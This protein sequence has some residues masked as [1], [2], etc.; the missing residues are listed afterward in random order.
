MNNFNKILYKYLLK[1]SEIVFGKDESV[2]RISF[3]G[4]PFDHARKLVDEIIEGGGMVVNNRTIPVVLTDTSVPAH[5]APSNSMGGI[6]GNNHILNLRNNKDIKEVIVILGVGT[7]LDKSNSTSLIPLGIKENIQ[8]DEWINH[9]M[10]QFILGEI[11]LNLNISYNQVKGGVDDIISNYRSSQTHQNDHIDQWSLLEILAKQ[12]GVADNNLLAYLLGSIND[13]S[14]IQIDNKVQTKIFS[15]IADSFESNGFSKT[16]DEWLG[17]DLDFVIEN[18]LVDFKSHLVTVCSAPTDFKSCPNFYYG[19]YLKQNGEIV[20]PNWWKTLTVDVWNE[21]L[22][23]STTIAGACK[24]SVTNSVFRRDKPCPVTN[25]EVEFNIEHNDGFEVGQTIKISCKRRNYELLESIE[26]EEKCSSIN[27]SHQPNPHNSPASYKFEIEGHKDATQKVISLNAYAPAFM[28]FISQ[29]DKIKPLKRKKDKRSKNEI[30]ESSLVLA[31]SGTH[32]IEYLIDDKRVDLQEIRKYNSSND[33]KVET[34]TSTSIGEKYSTIFQSDNEGILEFILKDKESLIF[35]IIRVSFSVSDSEPIGVKS[36]YEKLVTQNLSSKG[37]NEKVEVYND[38]NDLHQIQKWLV[39]CKETSWNPIIICPDYKEK[40]QLPDYAAAPLLSPSEIIVDCRPSSDIMLPPQELISLRSK[41]ISLICI[42]KEEDNKT[43]FYQPLIEYAELYRPD[44]QKTIEPLIIEYLEIY[45]KWYNGSPEIASWFDTMAICKT[46]KGIVDT[47]P[48]ALLLSPYHP[49]R[50]GWQYLSQ[51]ELNKAL[52]LEK[53][54]PAAGVINPSNFPDSLLI[55]SYQIESQRKELVFISL[56]TSSTVWSLMWNSDKLSAIDNKKYNS[57]FSDEFGMIIEG[58]DNG[59]S[60]SQV[61]HTL[62]DIYRIKSGQNSI[63]IEVH[64]ESAESTMFNHGV[65]N[66]I[67][68]NLGD[69]I[70]ENNKKVV[71]DIWFDSGGKSLEIYDTRP[72]YFQPSSEELVEYSKET[73]YGLLWYKQNT[74]NGTQ[75]FDLSIISHLTSQSP[76]TNS[77]PSHS[78]LTNGGLSRNRI[79]YSSK[80]GNS[81]L[82]F[83]ESRTCFKPILNDDSLSDILGQTCYEI[84]SDVYRASK[85]C[86]SSTPKL[87]FVN[88]CMLNADYCAISS[89]VVDPSAFFDDENNNYLWDYELPSYSNKHNTYSGFYLL[90]KKTDSVITSIKNSLKAIPSIGKISDEIIQGTLKEIAGRGIPTLK[91]LA[92]GG[93][94]ANGEIGMLLGMKF[95]QSFD[96]HSSS[97]QFAPRETDNN[98]NLIIPIDPFA[99]QL[100]GLYSRLGID[101]LRPDLVVLSVSSKNDDVQIKL[102][103]IEIKYR[104]NKMSRKD[105]M[106]AHLQCDNFIKLCKELDLLSRDFDLWNVARMQ[107]L[108]DM[109]SFAFGTYGRQL[110]ELNE[111]REWSSLQEQVLKKI[112]TPNNIIYSEIGRLIIVSDYQLTDF[113]CVKDSLIKDTL[114]VSFEDAKNVLKSENL[115]KF[116]KFQDIVGDWGLQ[117]A[118]I[119]ESIKGSKYEITTD[120]REVADPDVRNERIEDDEDLSINKTPEE[121]NNGEMVT[122]KLEIAESVNGDGIKFQVGYQKGALQNISHEF[123]P[124]NT[125][126]NQLNIGIVGDLGTGKTQLIKA[127]IYNISKDSSQNRGQSPKFLIIDTKRDYDGSGDKESDKKFV[128]DINAKVIK[129][130]KLPINLFDIRNSKDDNPAFTKAEFFIDILTKIYGGIQAVQSNALLEAVMNSFYNAGYEPFAEDYSNFKSPTLKDVFEE[131]KVNCKKVDTS[132]A[133]MNRLIQARL[134][135][136]DS[137]KTVGFNDFFNQTTVLS[138]G[139]MASNDKNLKMVMIIFMNL[140]REYML[141][142]KKLEFISKGDYQLRNIDSYLLIDEANLIMEYELS[143]LEDILLKGREFGIGIILSSQY[144][145]HF[146]KSGTNYAEPLLTWFV[147]KV[148][149]V[150]ARELQTL[151]LQNVNDGLVNKIKTLNCHYCL[152]KSLK[153]EG[154]IIEGTPFYKLIDIGL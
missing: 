147:H 54:C 25:S 49:L 146:K 9:D 151:G 74:P 97:F 152:Y 83:T 58:L 52:Q 107:F 18:A 101:Q 35:K 46:E 55:S 87:D 78:I 153:S 73:G 53:P 88:K 111:I 113:E 134:F 37:G 29:S 141:G 40:F 130:F 1:E 14:S 116:D 64:S 80:N 133:L 142:V 137:S 115:T 148:P 66:W 34:L 21:I 139:G 60:S 98:I 4:L 12:L 10:I 121:E 93:T 120:Y 106:T 75:E 45:R 71:R 36:I 143:V 123:H 90:A 27:W 6:C 67:E 39:D 57:I 59:L 51:R 140:Y 17:N 2:T 24:I 127:L 102:T 154:V 114:L 62:S 128:S 138:L 117:H 43:D 70:L 79:R 33:N 105:M 118:F 16:I 145:S 95:L 68:K 13:E 85:G 7:I 22:D 150:T 19:H 131:Y 28:F 23:E 42:D 41:L 8:T 3:T 99:G 65:K 144:L 112:T 32:E 20:I 63:K 86:L 26:I 91:T 38:W 92:S 125:N 30:W 103:P 48:Y 76:I 72:K 77:A 11:F 89:S 15:K 94:N 69:V 47:E 126:L 100:N 135:E 109:V 119:E 124:S 149:N 104:T 122:G 5:V 129:P 136:E 50:L 31:N 61:E 81:K 132:Y 82:T 84:E 56:N 110:H 108:S 44:L 96:K